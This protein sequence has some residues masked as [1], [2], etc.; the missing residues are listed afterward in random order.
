MSPAGT[1]VANKYTA[2]ASEDLE[3]CQVTSEHP[4]KPGPQG[5]QYHH[6]RPRGRLT[7]KG[8]G[9]L[10]TGGPVHIHAR[11]S[12]QSCKHALVHAFPRRSVAVK[13]MLFKLRVYVVT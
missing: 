10:G 2:Q 4:T 6:S 11:S 8:A 1:P 3:G 7:T 5:S 12:L 13:C 9:G